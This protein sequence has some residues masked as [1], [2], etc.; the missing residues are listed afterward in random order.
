MG[1]AKRLM[2]ALCDQCAVRG[3]EESDGQLLHGVYGRK[4]PYN[5]CMIMGLTNA[6]FWGD[7]YYA[8]G[9]VRL[10]REWNPYW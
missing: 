2:K 1:A 4:T 10:S 7:Y 8:E 6:I 5:D 9:L 3:P